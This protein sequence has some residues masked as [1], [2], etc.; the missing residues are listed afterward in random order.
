MVRKHSPRRCRLGVPNLSTFQREVGPRCLLKHLKVE[1]CILRENGA[2][3]SPCRSALWAVSQV[4]TQISKKWFFWL[5]GESTLPKRG[6]LAKNTRKKMQKKIM[7]H[8]I[9]LNLCFGHCS[10]NLNQ[11]WHRKVIL[12]L[13]DSNF[14]FTKKKPVSAQI[15]KIIF[16]TCLTIKITKQSEECALFKS[17]F[18][19]FRVRRSKWAQTPMSCLQISLNLSLFSWRFDI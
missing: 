12:L 5:F 15:L 17:W 6:L 14:E 13:K 16:S 11:K 4:S 9:K 3:H 10:L 19:S 7:L 2:K 1:K 8:A 18:T